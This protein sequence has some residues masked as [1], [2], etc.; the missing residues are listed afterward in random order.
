MDFY[1]YYNSGGGDVEQLRS[2]TTCSTIS[3]AAVT[4]TASACCLY[5]N[6][7]AE[8]ADNHMTD[9]R[10]GVQTG[11]FSNANP[12]LTASIDGN[13]IEASRRGIFYNLHYS[14][15]TPFAIQ[16]NIVTAVADNTVVRW[17]GIS[18]TSQQGAADVV[19]ANNSVN[20]SAATVLSVGY[21]IWN[22][23]TSADLTISGGTVTGVD[24]GVWA[25]NYE[26]Y[27][28]DAGATHIK[29]S[30]V[31]ITADLIGVYVLDSA[32]NT[33]GSKV[34]ATILGNNTITTGGA[35]TGIKVEKSRRVRGHLRQQ[36]VH[37]QQHHRHRRERWFGDDHGQPHLQQHDGHPVHDRRRRQR[38][39]QQFRRHD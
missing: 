1:N 2:P 32:S 25:N 30:G 20:G 29:V 23:P 9:V 18:I 36:C 39:Q 22:T 37:L 34:S 8:V 11:N 31:N 33:N 26:G 17:D 12:G 38:H 14:G 10:V 16:N 28:S 6:F 19:I 3:A 5:N 7:Y 15:A 27:F 35:G 13:T 4:A 21:N 24:Y